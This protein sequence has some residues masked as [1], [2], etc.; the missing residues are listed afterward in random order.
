MSEMRPGWYVH[1][2][3]QGNDHDAIDAAVT[4]HLDAFWPRGEDGTD[5]WVVDIAVSPMVRE[6]GGS[7][8][9]WEAD[10]TAQRVKVQSPTD[11]EPVGADR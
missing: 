7:I 11:H 2:D 9:S 6:G 3:V 10:V 8:V 5:G 1:F 4:A